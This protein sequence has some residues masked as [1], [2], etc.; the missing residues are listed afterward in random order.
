MKKRLLTIL[1][2]QSPRVVDALHV[3]HIQKHYVTYLFNG[4]RKIYQNR[5]LFE[6][7]IK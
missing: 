7:G 3:N 6:S 5:K 1:L 4:Y 2:Q